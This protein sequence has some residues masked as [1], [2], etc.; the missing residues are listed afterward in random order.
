MNI[1]RTGSPHPSI[2]LER[3]YS[4]SESSASSSVRELSSAEQ[5][6]LQA[7]TDYLKDHVFAAHKLPLSESAV[8]QDAVHAHNEQIDNIIDTRARRLL[9]EGETPASIGE[10]FAKA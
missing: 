4:A 3:F 5:T 8:D 2:E 6:N 1:N 10:T 7:I 9:D